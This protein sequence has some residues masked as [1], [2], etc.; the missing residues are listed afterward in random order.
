M[1]VLSQQDNAYNRIFGEQV[2]SHLIRNR[3][4]KA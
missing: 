4:E 2:N 1:G 3:N